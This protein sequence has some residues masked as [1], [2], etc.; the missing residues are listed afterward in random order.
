M[1]DKAL[2]INLSGDHSALI[3]SNKAVI[4]SFADM[5]NAAEKANRAI[6]GVGSGTSRTGGNGATANGGASSGGV[7]QVAQEQTKLMERETVKQTAIAERRAAQIQGVEDK[8]LAKE[9]ERQAKREQQLERQAI[10]DAMR[11]ER[12]AQKTEQIRQKEAQRAAAQEER[13]AK[14]LALIE[15]RWAA[16]SYRDHVHWEQKKEDAAKDSAERAN[17][18]WSKLANVGKSLV[19]FVGITS[20]MREI[21]GAFDAANRS[22]V[23]GSKF[24]VDYR[25]KLLEL[26]ALKGHLGESGPEMRQ[27]LAFRAQTLQG[28]GEAIGFSAQYENM[29]QASKMSGNISESEAQKLAVLAGSFQAADKGDPGAHATLAGSLPRLMGGKQ[30]ARDVFAKESQL[31]SIFQPGGA[32]FSSMIKQFMENSATVQTGL[33][34]LDELASLTSVFSQN[35][36]DVAGTKVGQFVRA[37][38]GGLGRARGPQ[39]LPLGDD[40][41]VRKQGEYLKMIGATE[42]MTPEGIGRRIASDLETQRKRKGADFNAYTYLR[43]Q[44]YGNKEDVES[45]LEF[46]GNVTAGTYDSTFKAPALKAPTSAIAE[47]K[48]KKFQATDI[49][50]LDRKRQI[51]EDTTKSGPGSEAMTQLQALRA[52]A[53]SQLRKEGQIPYTNWEELQN[54]SGMTAAGMRAGVDVRVQSIVERERKR[55]GLKS[56]EEVD[57][58]LGA[59]MGVPRRGKQPRGYSGV[60]DQAFASNVSESINE[61]V[62]AGGR[63]LPGF[64]ALTKALQDNADSSDK[65]RAAYEKAQ[66]GPLP[67]PLGPA[68]GQ[69]LRP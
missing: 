19:G 54:A 35:Q 40:D 44:G 12:S 38:L 51:M 60:T 33:M 68:P 25:E 52:M 36:P 18:V 66:G 53:V 15:D 17:Q 57:P 50:A 28:Q 61:A 16:R 41:E 34:P 37:T 58:D 14:E 63:A 45:V 8:W 62:A 59:A 21:R 56:F 31:Y 47:A 29:I 22:A 3:K 2:R 6:A 69:A 43:E 49:V 1:S 65:L 24:V 64:D 9:L 39:M 4:K 32:Q 27:Q 46:A 48:I 55:V 20:V 13:K 7:G 42:K 10:R 30:T 5:L 67:K 26:A 11:V 23:E